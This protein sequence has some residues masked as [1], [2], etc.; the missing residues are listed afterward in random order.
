[1]HQVG[2]IPVVK[3]DMQEHA[4]PLAKALLKGGISAI[5]VTFRTDAAAESIRRI[6]AECSEMLLL[7]GTVLNLEQAAQAI[8]C[9]ASGIVSPGINL[10]TVDWCRERKIPIIPGVATPSEA[11][12]CAR[13]GVQVMKLFPAE[14][15]GG[16]KMLKALSGPYASFCFMPTG[17][18]HPENVSEYLRL[19]NVVCCG[20]TWIVPD[21]ALA[22]EKFDEICENAKEAMRLL[23]EVRKS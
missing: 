21:Q 23:A 1:M 3:M 2:I 16:I 8:E 20:G 12:L 13:K 11:E 7:A 17:G 22:E 5:E 10:E 19:N 6:A 4:V 18:I 14:V 9:G 15:V